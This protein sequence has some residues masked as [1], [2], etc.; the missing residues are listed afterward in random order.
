[1]RR[2]ARWISE[3]PCQGAFMK[4]ANVKKVVIAGM[5]LPLL[6]V[7]ALAGDAQPGTLSNVI[8]FSSGVVLFYTDGARSAVPSCALTQ[9]TRFALDA[10]TPGGKVQLAG[11]PEAYALGKPVRIVGTEGC[12]TYPDSETRSVTSTPSM[13]SGLL[14]TGSTEHSSSPGTTTHAFRNQAPGATT[15]RRG[16]NSRSM[17]KGE[18]DTQRSDHTVGSQP[19]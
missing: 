17:C 15:R 16:W 7:A 8:F 6:P 11:L 18:G 1:M 13:T 3:S 9:Q 10:T 19:L 4:K 12:T 2:S 14:Q 5:L